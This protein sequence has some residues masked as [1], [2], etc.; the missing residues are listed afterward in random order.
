MPR[1]AGTSAPDAIP[2]AF[3]QRESAPGAATAASVLE[4]EGIGITIAP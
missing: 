1:D 2:S 4:S 3:C